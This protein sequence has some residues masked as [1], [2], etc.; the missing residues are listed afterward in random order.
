MK[1]KLLSMAVLSSLVFTANAAEVTPK[2]EAGVYGK[3]VGTYADSTSDVYYEESHMNAYAAFNL[4]ANS[5][6]KADVGTRS[7]IRQNT[8]DFEYEVYVDELYYKFVENKTSSFGIGRFNNPVGLYGKSTYDMNKHP[9]TVRANTVQSVDG[10]TLNYLGELQKGVYFDFDIFVGTA[11]DD[12]LING[13]LVD[14]DTEIN[15]GANVKIASGEGTFNFGLYGSSNGTDTSIDDIKIENSEKSTFYQANF[16]YEYKRNNFYTLIQY[17][18]YEINYDDDVDN[19]MDAV[20]VLLSYK[21]G[22]FIPMIGYSY[23][24]NNNFFDFSESGESVK[25]DTFKAG[26]R[27][28][29]SENV[30][31]IS[32]YNYVS[33]EELESDQVVNLG[34]TFNI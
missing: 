20:D 24:S 8:G 18:H 3:A 5:V 4:G 6:I 11:L 23:E 22:S 7:V 32:E 21:M 16:G 10:A 34:I 19:K 9:F 28:T 26:F 30:S 33:R 31:L 29:F 27:Y 1:L 13:Y 25:T 17:N 15:Y 12:Q 14:L 2:M